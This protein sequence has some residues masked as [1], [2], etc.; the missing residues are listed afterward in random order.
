MKIVTRTKC[1]TVTAKSVSDFDRKFN[2]ATEELGQVELEWDGRM[3]VHMLYEETVRIA[4][5]TK[6]EY[7]E[8]RDIHYYCKNCPHFK[9]GK[10]RRCSS[11]GC[12][13]NV[14]ERAKD[15]TPAC[16]LFY[17]E[18]ASGSIKARR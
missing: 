6:E 16:E 15:F 8:I 7:E 13:L 4:E 14:D 1:K 18:L 17:E 11:E 12:E 5:N 9:L 3:T 10:N 2:K